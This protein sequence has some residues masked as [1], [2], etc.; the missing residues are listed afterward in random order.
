MLP[1]HPEEPPPDDAVLDHADER[2]HLAGLLE[3]TDEF[4]R[5][6]SPKSAPN[7]ALFL[8]TRHGWSPESGLPAYLD[9]LGLTVLGLRDQ[10]TGTTS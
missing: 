2:D 3:L 5:Q 1:R 4:F 10:A 6:S 8:T 7:P 9:S